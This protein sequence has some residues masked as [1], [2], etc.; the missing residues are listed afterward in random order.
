MLKLTLP[1]TRR[2]QDIFDAWDAAAHDAQK[3][4]DRWR[5]SAPSDRRDAYVTYRA[6][7]DREERAAEMLAAAAVG[8]ARR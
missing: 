6:S 5:A 4:W 8:S 3:A 1:D 7:L 2:W